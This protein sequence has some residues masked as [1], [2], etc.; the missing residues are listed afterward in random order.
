MSKP[1]WIPPREW[2]EWDDSCGAADGWEFRGDME[3]LLPARCISVGFVMAET[4]TY[5]TI[6]P[7]VSEG[8][9]LGRLTI[10]KVAIVRRRSIR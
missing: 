5:L 6:A 3:P 1:D 4:E 8:L 2:I 9:V 10:P 7:T